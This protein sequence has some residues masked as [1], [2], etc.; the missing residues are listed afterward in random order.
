[1]IVRK[2]QLNISNQTLVWWPISRKQSSNVPCV[3][4]LL[5]YT[6]SCA[7]AF[8][9]WE[10]TYKQGLYSL[11]IAFSLLPYKE[12]TTTTGYCVASL[13]PTTSVVRRIIIGLMLHHLLSHLVRRKTSACRASF[14]QR[15]S[16]IGH[17]VH[18][19]YNLLFVAGLNWIIS[20]LDND[21]M[22]WERL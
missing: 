9:W 13:S 6:R 20:N 19:V 16:L 14:W 11:P 17:T 4:T 12:I 7:A 15:K 5:H 18:N 8:F 1:M 10:A 2:I 21:W 3:T 22:K